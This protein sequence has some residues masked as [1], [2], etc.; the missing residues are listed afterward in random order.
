MEEREKITKYQNLK[1]DLRTTCSL[2]ENDIIP[3]V[4]GET[5]IIKK[6]QKYS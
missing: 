6:T 4:I 1:N 3:V 5:E 2:K